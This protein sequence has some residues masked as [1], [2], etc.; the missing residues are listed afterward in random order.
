MSS[1]FTVFIFEIGHYSFTYLTRSRSGKLGQLPKR[2]WS[3]IKTASRSYVRMLYQSYSTT[4]SKEDLHKFLCV[5]HSLSVSLTFYPHATTHLWIAESKP[6]KYIFPFRFFLSPFRIFSFVCNMEMTKLPVPNTDR[7]C[8]ALLWPSDLHVYIIFNF[9]GS[10]ELTHALWRLNRQVATGSEK[11][12]VLHCMIQN[13]GTA[14]R[15]VLTLPYSIITSSRNGVIFHGLW[16][17]N[18]D[19]DK[20]EGPH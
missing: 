18:T 14:S 16:T 7:R 2:Q 1:E 9:S 19:I 4:N 13:W 5:S 20:V 17:E 8:I 11:S 10:V 12:T 3:Q 6:N 15:L